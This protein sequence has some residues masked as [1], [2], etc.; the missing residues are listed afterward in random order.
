MESANNEDQLFI[1]KKEIPTNY[2]FYE[3]DKYHKHKTPEK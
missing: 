1:I 3:V 2:T